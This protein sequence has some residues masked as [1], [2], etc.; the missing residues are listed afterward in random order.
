M[1]KLRGNAPAA[2]SLSKLRILPRPRGNRGR[3]VRPA[4]AVNITARSALFNTK[5]MTLNST[6]SAFIF[7]GQGSQFVGMGKNL[8][9]VFP[10]ANDTFA[11]ADEEL[12]FSLTKLAWEG[13]EDAL[14]DTINTQPALLAHSIAALRVF[15]LLC[16]DLRPSFVA[17]HSMGEFSA[18]VAAGSL[19]YSDALHLV[20]ARGELMKAAGEEVPGG[21]AAIL[22]LDIET[23]E[24]ICF[25]SSSK[26]KSVQVANDN[27]PG[28][29]VIS[30]SNPALDRAMALASKAGARKVVRL[31]VSIA[32]HSD[33]MYHAQDKFNHTVDDVS[34]GDP[35]VPVIGNVSAN[36]LEDAN[37]VR[38]DLKAQLNSRV[39]WTETIQF[40]ISK[41]V[42]TFYEIGSGSVLTGLLRRI[43]HDVQGITL[44][45]PEDFEKL[46]V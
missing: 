3:R 12:G 27:C 17:G 31:K 45:S 36:F 5:N 26:S 15:N 39:R 1:L 4:R 2:S 10:I 20:R 33:L 42:N 11:K 40:I 13:P 29:V 19:T 34:I 28:Q 41:G 37:Q 21:M 18:L 32:A 24:E 30:G 9:Q 14:H 38:N 44:G 16:P 8:A 35:T 25:E 22:G 43:D 23:L 6:K 7:P 46:T